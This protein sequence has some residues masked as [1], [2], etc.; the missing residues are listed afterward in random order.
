M[1]GFQAVIICAKAPVGPVAEF[2]AILAASATRA[3]RLILGAKGS[4]DS[5]ALCEDKGKLEEG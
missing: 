3:S 5:F 2:Y 4:L 1:P